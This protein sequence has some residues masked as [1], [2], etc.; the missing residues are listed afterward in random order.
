MS[1]PE[2]KHNRYIG[3][4]VARLEDRPLLTGDS[5]FIADLS[6]P[7][8]LHARIVRSAHA[9]GRIL[10]IELDAARAAPGVAAVWDASDLGDLPPIPFRETSIRGLGPY[11]QPALARDFVRYVGE[12][13]AVVFADDPY[14]AEDAADLVVADIEAL[15][16][17]LDATRVPEG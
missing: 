5:R 14:R 17:Y 6:F 2:R 12:P 15:T 1:G 4:S 8:Q 16:P 3:E 7:H 11:R 13:I 9:F 10:K